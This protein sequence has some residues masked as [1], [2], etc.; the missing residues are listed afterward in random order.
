MS[1]PPIRVLM[2]LKPSLIDRGGVG[3]FAVT[4]IFEGERV[5]SGVSKEDYRLLIPWKSFPGY[6]AALQ[7][8]IMSFCIGT[9][10]GFIP[11]ENFDF[12]RLSIEWYFNH[13]CEGNLGFDERGDFVARV[14]V[15]AGD[16]LAYDYALAES[17][18][19]FRMVCNCR[20]SHCR[21]IITGNDCRNE[22]FRRRNIEYMLPRLRELPA[23]VGTHVANLFKPSAKR[24]GTVGS[25]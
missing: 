7:R 23:R 6:D 14:R 13:S 11:P 20:K 10:D 21:R 17:N 2:E 8:K 24:L 15:A 12:N 3:V 16:E 22:D 1:R 9:P 25:R 19:S 4:D 18:P 5:A